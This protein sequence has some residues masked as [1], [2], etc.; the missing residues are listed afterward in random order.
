MTETL[1]LDSTEKQV[2]NSLSVFNIQEVLMRSPLLGSIR[3]VV[4][5][6]NIFISS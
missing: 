2:T 4:Q 3:P 6:L 5:F 1:F